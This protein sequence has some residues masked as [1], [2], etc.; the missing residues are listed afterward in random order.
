MEKNSLVLEECIRTYDREISRKTSLE[1]KASSLLST[2]ALVVSILNAFTAFIVAGIVTFNNLGILI[3]LNIIATIIIGISIYWSLDVLKIKK[4][5]IP[6]D[7]KNPNLI[8][9]KLNKKQ[10]DLTNDL[11][12][13]YLSIIPQIHNFNDIK[14]ISLESSR[15]FLIYGIFISFIG[16]IITL[17]VNGGL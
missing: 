16:L 14:V 1:S 17:F 10:D 3:I 4:H 13:R 9:E 15:T 12:D 7:I 6:F 8:M 2:N 5:F 11:I